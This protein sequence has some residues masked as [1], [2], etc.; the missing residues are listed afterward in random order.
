MLYRLQSKDFEEIDY[1]KINFPLDG[2]IELISENPNSD[3]NTFSRS[4]EKEQTRNP[5]L[6]F[7][8]AFHKVICDV[9]RNSLAHG[10]VNVCLSPLT[11]E[12]K[13]EL[14]DIDPKTKSVRK[15]RFELESFNDFLNSDAFSPKNC[16]NKKE[17]TKVHKKD[18]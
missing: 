14:T 11:L 9:V 15:I 8:D 17:D 18:S 10:N 1:R 12:R 16:Y 6:R 7:D 5:E 13:I 4:I 3:E 2:T